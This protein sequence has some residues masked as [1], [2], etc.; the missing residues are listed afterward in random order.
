M[1]RLIECILG[2]PVI[3]GLIFLLVISISWDGRKKF[4]EPKEISKLQ[5][6]AIVYK[7]AFIEDG[8]F[9]WNTNLIF[10]VKEGR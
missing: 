5:R 6:E 2:I 4:R 1:R 10:N 8:I 7:F 3:L 9:T